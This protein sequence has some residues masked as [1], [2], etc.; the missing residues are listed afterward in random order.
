MSDQAY[1]TIRR[2]YPRPI[3]RAVVRARN[4]VDRGEAA[5]LVRNAFETTLH[6]I[7]LTGCARALPPG[8]DEAAPDLSL[9]Q[10]ERVSLGHWTQ[11]VHELDRALAK[12][13][14]KVLGEDLRAQRDDL[15]QCLDLVRRVDPEFKRQRVGFAE[16]FG[17]ITNLR[18]LDAHVGAL[19]L[20][21]IVT[22]L[23][24][25]VEE[26]LVRLPILSEWDIVLVNKVNYPKT[27]FVA[28]CHL[29]CGDGEGERKLF[30]FGAQPKAHDGSLCLRHRTTDRWVELTPF[31]LMHERNL[32]FFKGLKQGEPVYLC[33]DGPL[34]GPARHEQVV[35]ELRSRAPSLFVVSASASVVEHLEPFV[36][37]TAA[38]GFINAA[39][40]AFLD[41]EVARLDPAADAGQRQ[42]IVDAAI[43]RFAP[44]A[45]V[46]D[47]EQDEPARASEPPGEDEDSDEAEEEERSASVH[48][49][50]IAPPSAE[51][52]DEDLEAVILA[53]LDEAEEPLTRNEVVLRV[54]CSVRDAYKVLTSLRD[55]WELLQYQRRGPSVRYARPARMLPWLLSRAGCALAKRDILDQIE[56][57]GAQWKHVMTE[58]VDQGVVEVSGAGA[59]RYYALPGTGAPEGD[60]AGSSG[61]PEDKEAWVVASAAFLRRM[62]AAVAEKGLGFDPLHVTPS[63]EAGEVD[64]GW[65]WVAWE[66]DEQRALMVSVGR[67]K[68]SRVTVAVTFQ[69]RFARRDPVFRHVCRGLGV[70]R[71]GDRVT[72]AGAV[73]EFRHGALAL[74][75]RERVEVSAL[76]DE[77]LFEAVARRLRVLAAEVVPRLASAEHAAEDDED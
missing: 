56:M 74:E 58:L 39:E 18:N 6:Y 41:G 77:G 30:E 43:R 61:Q 29:F 73:F 51:L 62:L 71:P 14:E 53:C 36:R 11:L 75:S 1:E 5:K 25:A 52:V 38:D 23:R 16:L 46:E 17:R 10:S 67:K 12:R 55:R 26:I 2:T 72:L 34:L 42:V 20:T 37:A 64:D 57:V 3:A 63:D 45:R 33:P 65:V 4:A 24:E 69:S 44:D 7:V 48:P 59:G 68:L 50:S 32:Y 40:L 22:P 70:R 21:S 19:S 47:E 15:P 49:P 9:L 28:D 54:G 66:P 35:T 76:G 27:G 13:G 8:E 31:V 60:P